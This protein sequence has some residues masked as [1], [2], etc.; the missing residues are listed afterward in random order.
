MDKTGY[1]YT[2]LTEADCRA[3]MRERLHHLEAEHFR[4]TLEMRIAG[5]ISATELNTDA[6]LRL[7]G[8]AVQALALREWLGMKE[9]HDVQVPG[10][11]L[12][13]Y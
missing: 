6:Q 4:L 5:V 11:E 8:M 2:L 3:I 13:S 1:E 12:E 9:L 7:A 10:A